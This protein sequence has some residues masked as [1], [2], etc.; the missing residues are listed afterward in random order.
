MDDRDYA[1][2]VKLQE[3]F[4]QQLKQMIEQFEQKHP[5]MFLDFIEIDRSVSGE[6]RFTLEGVNVGIS[7]QPQSIEEF[8]QS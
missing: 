4:T 1:V 2:R 3:E 8:I 7:K 5:D 6:L